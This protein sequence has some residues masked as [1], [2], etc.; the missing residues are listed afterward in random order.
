MKALRKFADAQRKHFEKGGRLELFFPF[1]EMADTFFFTTGEVTH[2]AS[3]VRDA[4]DLK[5]TMT[6][7]V[8]ALIPVMLWAMYNTGLQA[9]LAIAAGAEPLDNWRTAV[10]TLLGVPFSPSSIFA[11]FLHGALYYLPIYF[12]TLFVGG[13][14]EV[15]FAMVRKHDIN[16]GFLVTSALF[17]L[18]L[19][20]TIPLW[21]VGLGIAFGVLIGK[22]VFGGTGM[23]IFNPALVA[24]AFLYFAYPKEI[25]GDTMWI[26]AK[27]STDGYSG[28]TW[29]AAVKEG[30]AEAL[31]QGFPPLREA[32]SYF[33][34]FFGFEAGSLGETSM[35]LC[36]VGAAVLILTRVGSW[37]IMAGCFAGSAATVLAFNALYR[38]GIGNVACGVPFWWHWAMGGF[39]FAAVYMATDP[40]SA[41]F[42]DKG[43]L[44]YGLLIGV[45]GM[46]IRMFNPAFPGSWMLAILFM[47]MFSPLID[48]FVVQANIK[49]RLARNAA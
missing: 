13:H 25:T 12:V 7:V 1:Y 24:R 10:M 49:R 47:N 26:A 11:C 45:L 18:T 32:P 33:D 34:V 36:L 5:R 21:Q 2:G 38:A 37:R 39:A 19:P 31:Q 27:T 16:E 6:T 17:P 23:N 15:L 35:F 9:H 14:V 42:T 3:H 43:R 22:E 46:L 48:H 41:P 20:A 40:V 28:A 4:A 44:A 29:L 8:I 30:G